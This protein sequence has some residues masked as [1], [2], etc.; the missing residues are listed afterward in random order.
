MVLKYLVMLYQEVVVELAN[1]VLPSQAN[2]QLIGMA[3]N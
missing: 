1:V 2:G 3:D